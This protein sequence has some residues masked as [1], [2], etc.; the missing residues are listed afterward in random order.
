VALICGGWTKCKAS[1]VVAR[2][3]LEERKGM[4]GMRRTR[5]LWRLRGTEAK[6][7]ARSAKEG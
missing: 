1:G 5:S 2:L 4:G 7:L 3:V 6:D